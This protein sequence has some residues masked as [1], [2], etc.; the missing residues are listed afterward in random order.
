[1]I[2]AQERFD[3]IAEISEGTN[4][5]ILAALQSML[6]G[7]AL[8]PFTRVGAG[9][10]GDRSQDFVGLLRQRQAPHVVWQRR[11]G[12]VEEGAAKAQ[13]GIGRRNSG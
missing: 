9:H 4:D 13:G 8:D 1:M 7:Y 6:G 10:A 11:V 2:S 12:V 3:V 5:R